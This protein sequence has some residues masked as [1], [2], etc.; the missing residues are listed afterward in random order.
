MLSLAGYLRPCALL[1]GAKAIKYF[2]ATEKAFKAVWE[3][4]P[5]EVDLPKYHSE[6]PYHDIR[7]GE[8]RQRFERLS[9]FEAFYPENILQSSSYLQEDLRSR[10]ATL[11]NS[12]G[13]LLLR[14]KDK[15]PYNFAVE[16]ETSKKGPERYERK[17][18][19][20]YS[21]GQLDGVLYICSDQQIINSLVKID[22]SV[23]GTEDSILHY[24]LES[25]VLKSDGKMFFKNAKKDGL[26]FI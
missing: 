7:L 3:R 12:D 26:G 8:I 16:L 1:A 6:S 21:T 20:Y 9:Y 2:E 14:D 5:F 11:L 15:N 13:V 18:S 19:S 4:W 24:A 17:L 22:E 10:E 23:R 25:Y